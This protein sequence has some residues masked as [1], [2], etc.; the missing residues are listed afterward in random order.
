MVAKGGSPRAI[1]VLFYLALILA[2]LIIVSG[3]HREFL[4]DRLASTFAYNSEGYFFAVVIAA[5]IQFGLPRLTGHRRAVASL[6]L[7]IGLA[8]LGVYLL[9]GKLP[10]SIATLQEPAFALALIIPYVSLPRPLPR[11]VAPVVCGVSLAIVTAGLLAGSPQP[12]EQ[13]G[14]VNWVIG[15]AEMMV[16]VFLAPLVFDVFFPAMLDSRARDRH[17]RFSALIVGLIVVPVIV[18]LL[19]R[20]ARVGDTV[21]PLALNYLGRAH[22]SLIG[23]L[24][25]CVFFWIID[26]RRQPSRAG[27]KR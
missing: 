3:I 23:F 10:S 25:I 22:E 26:E 14:P 18:S 15:M 8:F 9:L 27:P 5:W 13:L 20:G 2:L 12:N 16:L 17:G 4:P 21:V 11:W 1:S 6:A 7:G 24:L 19:G